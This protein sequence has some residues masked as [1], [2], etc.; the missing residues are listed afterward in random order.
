[1]PG[2]EISHD[3]GATPFIRY[4]FE[5]YE[6]ILEKN[7]ILAP[8]GCTEKFCQAGCFIHSAEPK[9]LWQ[10]GIYTEDC[11][12]ERRAQILEEIAQSTKIIIVWNQEHITLLWAASGLEEFAQVYHALA[13]RCGLELLIKPQQQ[14]R[15]SDIY[16]SALQPG[17]SVVYAVVPAS[18]ASFLLAIQKP[19][20]IITTGS[21]FAPVRSLLQQRIQT[22]REWGRHSSTTHPFHTAPISAG[23][24]PVDEN[25]FHAVGH[26]AQR[27][28][29]LDLACLVPSKREKKRVQ[30]FLLDKRNEIRTR[31]VEQEGYVYVCGS[32]AMA[33]GVQANLSKILVGKVKQIMGE[34]YVEKVS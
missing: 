4:T 2:T 30:G 14:G 16:I 9:Q 28:R 29:V 12:L 15:F 13:R 25:L 27:H 24:R 32:A 23:F 5:E 22:A 20:V 26:L 11:Y 3:S 19:L 34:R 17:G 31:L 18:P 10:E 21:G 7:F 6:R 1:M 8:T 33:E